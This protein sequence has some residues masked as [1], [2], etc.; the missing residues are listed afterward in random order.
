MLLLR[1]GVLCWLA[2]LSGPGVPLPRGFRFGFMT[3]FSP[4]VFYPE[5]RPRVSIAVGPSGRSESAVDLS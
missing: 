2:A 4:R 3:G 1:C 5:F